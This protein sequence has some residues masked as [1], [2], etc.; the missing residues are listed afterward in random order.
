MRRLLAGAAAACFAFSTPYAVAQESFGSKIT[1]PEQ[2]AEASSLVEKWLNGEIPSKIEVTYDGPPIELR[3]AS[4]L[5]K[6]SGVEVVTARALEVLNKEAN[7]KFNIK[8]YYAQSLHPHREGFTAVRDGIADMS[9]C[10][11]NFESS[12]FDLIHAIT[13]P[14]VLGGSAASTQVFTELYPKYFKNEYEKMGVLILNPFVPPPYNAIGSHKY[15]TLADWKGSKTKVSGTIQTEAMLLLGAVPNTSITAGESY[16]AL[17]RGVIDSVQ[18][19]DAIFI[20]FKLHEIA[21]MHSETSLFSINL[22]GCMSKEWFEKLPPD[23]Q[24]VVYHWA[25]KRNHAIVQGFY[26]RTLRD[27]RKLMTDRGVKFVKPSEEERQKW[28]AITQPVTDKWIK[29]AEAKGL[30]A[31]QLVADLKQLSAKYERMSWNEIFQQ[32]LD[33]PVPGLISGF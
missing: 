14:G 1:T 2:A 3:Y 13:L 16:T 4:Y 7:G 28:L 27:A 18:L 19:N 23:L 21:R 6:V 24:K 15:E 22:E 17:Q 25:Q 33:A 12:S 26:E 9:Y 20:T 8:T 30:P 31:K 32:T 29:D 11:A 5:P 10:F